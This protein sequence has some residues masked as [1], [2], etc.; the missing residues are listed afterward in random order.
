MLFVKYEGNKGIYKE[1]SK[2]HKYEGNKGELFESVQMY[3]FKQKMT[4]QNGRVTHSLKKSTNKNF[5]V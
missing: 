4:V 3:T 2:G 1:G 5:S